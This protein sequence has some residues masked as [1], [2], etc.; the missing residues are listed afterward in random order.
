MST[1][2]R[3]VLPA[4][5]LDL[6]SCDVMTELSVDREHAVRLALGTVELQ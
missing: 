4:A 1:I 2:Y 3:F 6:L 5:R